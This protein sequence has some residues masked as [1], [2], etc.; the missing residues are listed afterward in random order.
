MAEAADDLIAW[1][2]LRR[3]AQ[4]GNALGALRTAAERRDADQERAVRLAADN[5]LDKAFRRIDE[6]VEARRLVDRA[7]RLTVAGAEPGGAGA[8]AVHLFVWDAVR[9]AALDGKHDG[10]LDRA[11]AVALVGSARVEWLAALRALAAEGEIGQADQR[12]IRG[13]AG[14]SGD[15]EPFAGVAQEERVT[16]ALALLR[17]LRD[18]L[19]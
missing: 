12:R 14:R 18:V 13:L 19:G 7:L 16:A 5:L 10:W 11:E 17:A 4:R 2:R 6:D 15:H 1:E 8:L 3:D 9:E